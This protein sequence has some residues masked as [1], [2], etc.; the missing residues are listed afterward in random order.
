MGSIKSLNE[1]AEASYKQ[2]GSRRILDNP[3]ADV[4]RGRRGRSDVQVKYLFTFRDACVG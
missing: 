2:R 1:H 3:A 4:S